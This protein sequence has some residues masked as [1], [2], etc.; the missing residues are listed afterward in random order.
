MKKI[1]LKK[2][3]LFVLSFISLSVFSAETLPIS[4]TLDTSVPSGWVYITNNP[5][6]PDPSFY[7][8]GGLKLNYE[9][10]GITSPEFNAQPTVYVSIT[11]NALNANTRT[12][13]ASSDVFT[14]YGLNATGET[15]ATATLQTIAVGSVQVSLTGTDIAKVETIMTGYYYDGTSRYNVSLGNV[16]ISTQ[17]NALSN[18]SSSSFKAYLVGKNLTVTNTTATTIDLYSALGAKLQTLELVNGTADM[19][20]FSKGLYIVRAGKQ[21][22]KIM[23]K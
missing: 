18:P 7:S 16:T 9:T 11:I 17:P 15:V 10:M 8:A 5:T 19:S 20:N 6:Y 14:F 4:A 12:V 22:A 23:L 1:T 3:L 21:T 2:T 13:S